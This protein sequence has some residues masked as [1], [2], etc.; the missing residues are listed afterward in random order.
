MV[1]NR[2]KLIEL[3]IG[4]LFNSIVHEILEKA[5]SKELVADKYRKELAS[6]FEIARMYCE[7]INPVNRS[8][9]DKDV[10]YIKNKIV[11]RVKSELMIRISKGYE[12]IDLELVELLTDKALKDVKIS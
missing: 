1:Q 6:S 8:L 4:N 9:S 11:A 3:F 5:V 2:N 10:F 12:N 7:K